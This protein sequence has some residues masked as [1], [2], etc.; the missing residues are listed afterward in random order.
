M[1]NTP[2]VFNPNEPLAH[3]EQC[4]KRYRAADVS[5]LKS[6]GGFAVTSLAVKFLGAYQQ[7]GVR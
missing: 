6:G 2:I 7:L 1:N 3:Y 5:R 4:G